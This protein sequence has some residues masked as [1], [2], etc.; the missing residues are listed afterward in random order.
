MNWAARS[1]SCNQTAAMRALKM[2]TLEF[3]SEVKPALKVRLAHERR[4]KEIDEPMR[5]LTRSCH[6]WAL[7]RVRASLRRKTGVRARPAT[8][9]RKA[10]S[11]TGPKAG[12]EM[13][14]KRKEAPQIAARD[15]RMR[16]SAMR[17]D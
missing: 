14:M 9:M 16:T 15:R 11:G 17:T 10:T 1:R 6:Q 13:R 4:M 5:P 2:G 7:K 8:V 3:M 12:A